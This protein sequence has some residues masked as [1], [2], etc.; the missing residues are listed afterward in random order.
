MRPD[1]RLQPHLVFDLLGQTTIQL[2]QEVDHAAAGTRNRLQVTDQSRACRA[3]LQ[4]GRQV[5]CQLRWTIPGEVLRFRLQKEIKRVDDRHVGHQ[6][7][8]DHQFSGGLGEHQAGLVIALRILLPVNQVC[9]G[10]DIQRVAVDRR[11]AVGSWAQADRMGPEFDRSIV[12]IGCLVLQ[13]NPDHD[14][15]DR[16]RETFSLPRGV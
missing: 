3:H 10:M 4:V 11:T 2:H 6:V 16:G 5:V 1:A 15:A 14:R 12:L 8:L 7:D 9:A 13:G